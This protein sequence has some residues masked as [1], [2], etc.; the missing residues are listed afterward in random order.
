MK[1]LLIR[2]ESEPPG[3]V[4]EIVQA[5]STSVDEVSTNELS[6][7]VSRQGLGVDRIV[8]WAAPDDKA[9]QA[10]ATTYAATVPQEDPGA[11]V[12]V[13]PANCARRPS[14][15]SG[16]RCLS[17]PQDEDKLRMLFM[18]GG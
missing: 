1:T 15:V 5:G 14:G 11:L 16:D 12:Y 10:L 8:V 6:T 9:V 7:F 18:T 3:E 2:G 17:W 4:R 13:T